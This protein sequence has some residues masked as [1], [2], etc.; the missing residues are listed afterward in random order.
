MFSKGLGWSIFGLGSA[1]AFALI[2]YIGNRPLAP[3]SPSA[4]S[5]PKPLQHLFD[6]EAWTNN[7]PHRGGMVDNLSQQILHPGMNRTDV[8][9]LLGEPEADYWH[10]NAYYIGAW[11]RP[12]GK[13][14]FVDASFFVVFYDA[15]NNFSNAR[16]L[17]MHY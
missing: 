10:E 4:G 7:T 12:P 11:D 17:H 1:A 9:T 16:V 15:S 8:R 14:P 6:Q 13:Q 5:Y 2:T 3:L